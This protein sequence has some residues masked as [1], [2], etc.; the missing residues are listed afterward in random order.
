[1]SLLLAAVHWF[2]ANWYYKKALVPSSKGKNASSYDKISKVKLENLKEYMRDS[3][4]L[5][6]AAFTQQG[7]PT[8]PE[9]GGLRVI[10]CIA[11]S[12]G[13]MVLAAYSATL[14]SFLA[15]TGN[16][17]PFDSLEDMKKLTGYRLGIQKGSV[18]EELFKAQNILVYW[19]A[20]IVLHQAQNFLVYWNALIAPYS[21][22][23]STTYSELRAQA[24]KDPKFAYIGSYEVQRL[25]PIGSCTFRSARQHLV[26]NDGALAWAKDFPYGPVFDHVYVLFT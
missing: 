12:L 19:N 8:F 20:L 15:V 24:L 18:L 1:M 5:V 2:F 17:L 11:Y 6:W 25:D 9:L 4:L 13:L 23:V 26:F 7:W 21:G 10:V 16:G 3:P 22:T 14:V